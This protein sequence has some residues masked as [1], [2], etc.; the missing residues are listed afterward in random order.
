MVWWLKPWAGAVG[1][2]TEMP[3]VPEVR[4]PAD[5]GGPT[6]S[7]F[8]CLASRLIDSDGHCFALLRSV[9]EQYAVYASSSHF[10]LKNVVA[11]L[12]W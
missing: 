3:E 2:L 7:E 12:F 4:E 5:S 8:I 6:D 9:L 1:E 10:M 11:L